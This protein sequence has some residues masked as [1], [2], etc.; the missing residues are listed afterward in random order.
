MK[1]ISVGAFITDG[2]VYLA[3]HST[4]NPFYDLPKGLQEPGESAVEVC[5]RETREETG[6]RLEPDQL[7]D[8]GVFPYLKNKDL[9]LFMWRTDDL[10]D[11]SSMVCTSFFEHPKT[12]KRIPEVDGFRYVA[13]DE[14]PARM[15]KNMA[16]VIERITDRLLQR[17]R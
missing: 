14:T 13:F 16:R 10:P 1:S 11:V 7:I 12:K 9:H 17:D 3:C 15:T 2:H 8:L 5:C 4:G 6:I